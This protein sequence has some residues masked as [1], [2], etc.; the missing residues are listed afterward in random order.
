[1]LHVFAYS[2]RPGT[3]AATMPDQVDEQTKKKRSAKLIELGSEI[4]AEILS[5]IAKENPTFEVL[6]ESYEDGFV[7]GHTDTFIEVKAPSERPLHSELKSVRIIS[8]VEHEYLLGDI[9]D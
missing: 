2:K 1:M 5:D 7:Y 8:S 3:P 9:I 4:R 6:F